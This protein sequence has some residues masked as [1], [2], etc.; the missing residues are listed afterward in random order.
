MDLVVDDPVGVDLR[1]PV[2]VEHYRL[3]RPEVGRV[4]AG[5]VGAVVQEVWKKVSNII[6]CSVHRSQQLVRSIPL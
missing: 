5:V 2:R 6:E 4:D 3:V 1:V